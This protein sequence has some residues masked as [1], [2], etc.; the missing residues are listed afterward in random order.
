MRGKNAL[1]NWFWAAVVAAAAIVCRIAMWVAGPRPGL[2]ALIA[3]IAF[4]VLLI[5]QLIRKVR[6][7]QNRDSLTGAASRAEF[8]SYLK[9]ECE[10]CHRGSQ[11]ISV[12]V[13]DCDEFK[14]VNDSFGHCEG[15]KVLQNVADVLIEQ[16]GASGRVGRFWGD[17]FAIVLP[18]ADLGA[19]QTILQR[20]QRA[21]NE[22]MRDGEWPVTFSIGA[23]A[24]DVAPPGAHELLPAADAAMYAVKR[25]G[26][27]GLECRL[28]PERGQEVRQARS[29][30]PV[31]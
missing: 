15:D 13:L 22:R 14:Q 1:R 4:C 2:A 25:R 6:A 28:M 30:R 23:A 20:T 7:L 16:T 9:R 31:R 29:D 3:I 18:E 12:V 24:F 21:L 8:F 5:A 26:R 10:S 19:V 27:N 17:A 11:P